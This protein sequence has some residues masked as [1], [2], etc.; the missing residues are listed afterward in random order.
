[1]I[2]RQFFRRGD[3]LVEVIF[4]FAILGTIIGFAFTGVIQARRSAVAAQQRTQ[5]LLI[6]QYQTNAL[7]SYRAGLPWDSA[8]G[9]PSFID[10]GG[11]TTAINS[12]DSFCV[13]VD[14]SGPVSKWILVKN[15]IGPPAINCNG[16]VP[17]LPPP[18]DGFTIKIKFSPHT[19]D[20]LG[21]GTCASIAV[22]ASVRADISVT[23]IG[24]SGT[25]QN[26]KNIVILTKQL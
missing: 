15:L 10:G 18:S 9:T 2:R 24:P 1:M 26:L 4:A 14:N 23:W 7:N 20:T 3:T 5:A 11:V 25:E 19:A 21:A 13:K 22:C 6:A 12:T 17:V 16:L 8:S